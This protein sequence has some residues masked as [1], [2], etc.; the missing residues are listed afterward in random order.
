MGWVREVPCGSGPGVLD[1][2]VRCPVGVDL[3]CLMG[4]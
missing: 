3:E 2:F 4:S 1:G